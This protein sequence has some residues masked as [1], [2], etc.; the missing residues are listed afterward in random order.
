MARQ[1]ER[2]KEDRCTV[3]ECKVEEIAR[4]VINRQRKREDK[5]EYE[6]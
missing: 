3:E 5:G 1:W 2:D 4:S 6:G